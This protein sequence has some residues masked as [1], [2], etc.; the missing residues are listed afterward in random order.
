MEGQHRFDMHDIRLIRENPA[1]FD[2]GLR[3]RGLE[4]LSTSLIALDER[5]REAIAALQGAQERR[6]SLSKEI[7]Q[8]KAKKDEARAQALMAEVARLKDSAPQLEQAERGAVE[9]LQAALASIPNTP[10]PDVPV[11]RDEHDNVERHRFG[12]PREIG[13]ARQHFEIGD[14]LGLMDF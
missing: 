14:K 13:A 11:G 7:G 8:A 3:K 1:A 12:A 6:N 4:P 5:R 10:N 9:Q 2:E